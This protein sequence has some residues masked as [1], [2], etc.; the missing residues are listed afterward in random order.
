MAVAIEHWY[1]EIAVHAAGAA[2]AGMEQAVKGAVAEFMRESA[3]FT[4]ELPGLTLRAGKSTYYIPTPDEGPIICLLML[5]YKNTALMPVTEA[6]WISSPPMGSG[7]A[8]TRFHADV[9]DNNKVVV[10]P[11]PESTL[12]DKLVPYVAIGYSSTCSSDLPNVF[13]R[14]WYDAIL[15]GALKRLYMQPNKPYTNVALATYHTKVFRTGIAV[16]RDR[17]RKQ[18]TRQETPFRFPSWA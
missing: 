13:C 9:A 8:P 15:S 6:Q 12:T 10:A 14:Q 11:T 7:T 1:D 16:A 18:F 5:L 2:T 17:A 4:M 3:A